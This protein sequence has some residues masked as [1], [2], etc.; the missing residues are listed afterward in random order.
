MKYLFFAAGLLISIFTQAQVTPQYYIDNHP[1][2]LGLKIPIYALIPL[3]AFS[4]GKGY[5]Q[6]ILVRDSFRQS[7]AP[8]GRI[9]NIYIRHIYPSWQ[10]ASPQPCQVTKLRIKMTHTTFPDFDSAKYMFSNTTLL[11]APDTVFMDTTW[12][13]WVKIPI[14]GEIMAYTD[15]TKN[16]VIEWSVDSSGTGDC[17]ALASQPSPNGSFLKNY[18]GQAQTTLPQTKAAT[19]LSFID[20]G[21]DLYSNALESLQNLTD[22]RLYPNPATNQILVSMAIAHPVKKATLTLYGTMGNIALRQEFDNA[23][24]RFFRRVDVGNLPRGIYFAELKADGER[25]MKKLVLE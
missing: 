23:D 12:G 10:S 17:T 9:K 8:Y 21:F 25:V 19:T 5:S 7:P 18:T 1:N 3:G 20:F 11:A 6:S 24:D 14:P 13:Y 15:T 4:A 2:G 22:L 16:M